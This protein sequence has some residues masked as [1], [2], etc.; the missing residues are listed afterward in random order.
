M[1]ETIK[2]FIYPLCSTCRK[3]IKWLDENDISYEKFNII[4]SPPSKELLIR[5]LSQE[6]NKKALFN[7]S[8]ISYRKLGASKVTAMNQ[9][10]TIKALQ[11]DPKLIKR[12]FVV[13]QS[14]QILFGFKANSWSEIFV[15]GVS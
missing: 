14:S 9:D 15:G 11:N 10:Q 8:G 6:S 5:A 7:T 2:V 4:E 3:A 1:T 13:T 12:P